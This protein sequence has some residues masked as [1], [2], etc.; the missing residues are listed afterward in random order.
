VPPA[1]GAAPVGVSVACCVQV[2][3]ERTNTRAVPRLLFSKGA[4]IRA[5]LPSAERATLQP[6]CSEPAPSLGTSS[7]PCWICGSIV[8]IAGAAVI[9]A[10]HDGV[11]GE[12]HRCGQD[13]AGGV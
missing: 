1:P 7:G 2:P 5:V 3:P 11:P 13:V 6:N 8:R 4:P 10:D 9:D 12:R